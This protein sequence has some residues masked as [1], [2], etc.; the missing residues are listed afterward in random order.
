MW[1]DFEPN[2]TVLTGLNAAGKSAVLNAAAVSLGAFLNGMEIKAPAIDLE[3]VR[4]VTR[5]AGSQISR[6]EQYPL[7]ITA[8]AEFSNGAI[9]QWTREKNSSKGRTTRQ[10]AQEILNYGK[11]LR[12]AIEE[13]QKDVILPVLGFYGTNRLWIQRQA[14]QYISS[15]ALSEKYNLR[16]QGYSDCLEG[17]SN[18]KRLMSWVRRQTYRELQENRKI[19]ELQA[20]LNCLENFFSRM[21]DFSD[22]QIRFGVDSEELE[23]IYSTQTGD[24]VLRP[25]SLLSD[26]YR[27]ILMLAADIAWRMVMLNPS[28]K[29][30]AENT[31]G[32]I[33]IDEIELHIHPLWQKRIISALTL[34]FPHVQF[35]VTTHAP[36]ILQ[37]VQADQLRLLSFPGS[38]EKLSSCNRGQNLKYILSVL[39]GTSDRPE[40][41]EIQ[42]NHFDE[43]IENHQFGKARSILEAL[44]KTVGTED[45][46]IVRNEITLECAE[47]D[48]RYD[49]VNL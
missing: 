32:I 30:P 9:R 25:F 38:P 1:I 14:K 47:D 5:T 28:L 19:P 29:D 31:P 48:A 18:E 13:D 2:I 35:I 26:G 3:D 11:D 37:S 8:Q 17:I 27:E 36:L 43:A 44:E 33:L 39:M 24:T 4:Y 45:P 40:D 49:G 46:D 15:K 6:A 21:S 7:A 23:V 41:I 16:L 10:N 20:F 34:T 42:L 12:K 22:V